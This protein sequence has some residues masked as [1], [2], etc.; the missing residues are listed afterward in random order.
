MMVQCGNGGG[1]LGAWVLLNR[2]G[3]GSRRG[4]SRWKTR[5]TVLVFRASSGAATADGKVGKGKD[6]LKE[7]HP[8]LDCTMFT[9]S[10]SA[11]IRSP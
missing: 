10:L 5:D 8:Y 3:G 9:A 11:C 4:G 7:V 6:L 1:I 2:D